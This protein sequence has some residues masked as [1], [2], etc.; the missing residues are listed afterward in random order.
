MSDNII[1]LNE[2]LIKD[3][4]K[5]LSET[6]LKKHSTHCLTMKPMSW[7]RQS[8]TNVPATGR[9]IAPGIMTEPLLRLLVM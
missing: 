2:T 1:Q 5:I 7:S 9:A 6:A 8:A 4:L 3:H